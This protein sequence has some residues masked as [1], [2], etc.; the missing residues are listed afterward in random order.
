VWTALPRGI[1][2]APDLVVDRVRQG[3]ALKAGRPQVLGEEPRLD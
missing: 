1:E 3:T 2:D